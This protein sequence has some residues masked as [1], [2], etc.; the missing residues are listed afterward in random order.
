MSSYFEEAN[1]CETLDG[2]LT[3]GV[4]LRL[5]Y[6]KQRWDFDQRPPPRLLLIVLQLH[7]FKQARGARPSGLTPVLREQLPA[8]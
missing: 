5:T 2:G 1:D 8:R 4:Y 3:W 7:S 6:G